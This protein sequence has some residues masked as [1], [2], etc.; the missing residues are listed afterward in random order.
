MKKIIVGLGLVMLGAFAHA[1]QGLERIIVEKFYVSNAADSVGSYGTLPVGSVTYRI[2]A[3]MLPGYKFQMAYGNSKHSLSFSTSTSFFNNTDRGA[4]T[5]NNI[6]KTN[7]GKNT[8]LLDSWLSVGAACSGYN[9][10]LK[11]EDDGVSTLVNSNGLLKNTDA[12]AGIPL[13][14]QD[15]M[16][17]GTINP[18]TFVGITPNVFNDGSSNGNSFST[19]NGAWA[20]QTGVNGQ[21]PG[22]S[23][24]TAANR[25]L[26]AQIT[27]NGIFHYEL[28]IQIGTPTGGYQL[29]VAK[30][31]TGNEI[32]IPSLMGT[33]LTL[34]QGT[35]TQTSVQLNWTLATDTK[36]VKSY[37][38]FK[39]GISVGSTTS[40]TF[41]VEGLIGDSTYNFTVNAKDSLGNF[42]ATS[43]PFVGKTL[44]GV[45]TGTKLAQTITFGTLAA[46]TTLDLPFALTAYSSAKLPITYT[47]S[48]PTVATVTG[49][50][51]RILKAGVTSITA[52]QIGNAKINA[53]TD[54]KQI[55]TI[56]KVAQTIT[57]GVLP[58]Y[59][60]ADPST[61]TLSATASS[62]LTVSYTSDNSAV[63]S[64]SGNTVTII[65]VGVAHITASQVGDN[66]FNAALNIL[67]TLTVTGVPQTITFGTLPTYT[68]VDLPFNLVASAN[69][70]LPVSFISDNAAVATVSGNSVAIVGVGV[71]HIT[72]S[73]AGNTTFSA[74]TNVLQTLTVTTPAIA[75]K[76]NNKYNQTISFAALPTRTVV[77]LPF[78][79]TAKS[80]SLLP[81]SYS[82]DNTAVATVS[83]NTVTIVG[84]GIANITASQAGN[85]GFNAA[86]NVIQK[87]TVTKLSQ[88]ITFATLPT[89]TMGD[90]STFT[91]SGKSTSLL[92]ISYV[93]D[94]SAVATVSGNIVTIVGA[95]IANITASQ[96]GNGTFN[97]AI[98]VIQKLTVNKLNQTILFGALPTSVSLGDSPFALAATSSS[99]LKVTYRSA[100]TSIATISD[101][102]L[103]IVGIGS[104]TIYAMQAGNSKYN[105]ALSVF[106]VLTV[107]AATSAPAIV[108]GTQ[109]INFVTPAKTVF[110]LPFALSG[111]SSSGLPVSYTTS[112]VLGSPITDPNTVATVDANGIVTIV[113]AGTINITATQSGN[114][115]YLSATPVVKTFTVT[116]LAQVIN[117]AA[118][119]IKNIVDVPFALSLT[120]TSGLPITYSTSAVYPVIDPNTVATVDANG[121]VT[122]VGAGTINIIAS[123][124]GNNNYLPATSVT[125]TLTVNKLSQTIKVTASGATVRGQI[126]LTTTIN[127]GLIVAYTNSDATTATFDA[128][129]GIVTFLQPGIVTI[130]ASQAGN[131]IYTPA[132]SVSVMLTYT[133]TIPPSATF[134]NTTTGIADVSNKGI[135][136]SVY[137]NPATSFIFV[138]A[139]E[140]STVQLF[141]L[142]GKQIYSK[143]NVIANQKE[144]LNVQNLAEG[145]YFIKVYNDKFSTVKKV[146]INK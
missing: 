112:A 70:G 64:V 66:N 94:N 124:A 143:T 31:P 46:K 19:N 130:T 97:A 2:Y 23:G 82:S 123:Q 32:S 1:Q 48:D 74:A 105:A 129:T 16:I 99:L 76:T 12:S 57:F 27:T 104:D 116:K 128:T 45:A 36:K 58:T 135:N 10:V 8:V 67:Q 103:T 3:D 41:N 20:C 96:A 115:D 18:V 93:S 39:N 37:D 65:G 71:A 117:F 75:T 106:K 146:V 136:V 14:S 125:K 22:A 63:A 62:G 69:S 73:Q 118:L 111:T 33:G 86:I 95:G 107:K 55:L 133:G 61:F 7:T 141:D 78:N 131:D 132:I 90:P 134:L 52:S 59:T 17:A 43:T 85:A 9:G 34:A 139:S 122:I 5:P 50:I 110:D 24:P 35:T 100:N 137:P 28:N 142:N 83:G 29:F 101:S 42:I 126:N 40:Q 25:V 47:S 26:I 53:A 121:I 102:T 30:N 91:L 109:T 120:S 49:N 81:I 11:S 119:P 145:I 72:A 114:G 77:D 92:P 6:S 60:M 15:G 138:E 98:N 21:T 113:G 140:N 54:V 51:V 127:S 89:K 144:E 80:T 88:T 44:G 4:T 87:L 79:L 56:S 84:A 38:V 68:T 108:K 13:T